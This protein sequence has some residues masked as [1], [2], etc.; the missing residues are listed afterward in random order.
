VPALGCKVLSVPRPGGLCSPVCI[1]AT[2]L[3]TSGAVIR[4]TLITPTTSGTAGRNKCHIMQQGYRISVGVIRGA[5]ERHY[6][7]QARPGQTCSS[8][9]SSL[10]PNESVQVHRRHYPPTAQTPFPLNLDFGD[11]NT[12]KS[13]NQCN[14]RNVSSI[15]YNLEFF[16]IFHRL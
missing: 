11:L 5:S 3:R 9:L 4:A 1:P 10:P 12:K 13:K 7:V 14:I 6:P 8:T 16:E 15:L 2:V